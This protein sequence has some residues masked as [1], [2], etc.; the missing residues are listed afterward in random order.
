[1]YQFSTVQDFQ[2]AMGFIKSY[3]H[4]P[5]IDC[6]SDLKAENKDL[7]ILVLHPGDIRHF[8]S[9]FFHSAKK[10]PVP[11]F[12]FVF[13]MEEPLQ[14]IRAYLLLSVA[15]DEELKV[16]ERVET[17]LDLFWNTYIAAPTLRI[18]EG[19][20]KGLED[21]L[22]KDGNG[23]ISFAKMKYKEKDDIFESVQLLKKLIRSKELS[24]ES[25]DVKYRENRTRA[26][27]KERYD[28]RK[29]LID[30]DYIWG[31]KDLKLNLPNGKPSSPCI[32][33]REYLCFRDKGVAYQFHA[34]FENNK[35]FNPTLISYIPGKQKKERTKC[36]VLGFWGDILQSPFFTFGAEPFD[37]LDFTEYYRVSNEQFVHDAQDLATRNLTL[38][39]QLLAEKAPKI[40]GEIKIEIEF[41]REIKDVI[42]RHSIEKVDILYL[43]FGV[44]EQVKANL[45]D[46]ESLFK[47]SERR[48]IVETPF[49][50]LPVEIKKRKLIG[51]T[52]AENLKSAGWK[53][54]EAFTHHILVDKQKGSA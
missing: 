32:S 40:G 38:V 5:A 51:E 18:C 15:L 4:S 42:K 8:F 33:F 26:L 37:P 36:E 43:P 46:L 44:Y 9:T 10:E 17:F 12:K 24:F 31:I 6:L 25:L 30:A 1:M 49:Y 3:D 41:I 11:N 20:L 53:V 52:M 2:N 48:L 28:H 34:N 21:A 54:P 22:E 47:S 35:T 39:F 27:F 29:N 14:I 23:F 45:A 16:S 13:A 50:M 19:K 7:T